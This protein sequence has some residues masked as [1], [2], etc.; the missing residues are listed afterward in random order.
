MVAKKRLYQKTMG[1]RISP[2]FNDVLEMNRL[3]N[4]QRHCANVPKKCLFG[5]YP[6]P[7]NCR[8]CICP[9]GLAGPTCGEPDNGTK[10]GGC[11]QNLNATKEVLPL[12]INLSGGSEKVPFT[13]YGVCH[14]T[15]EAPRN[16]HIRVKVDSM[17]ANCAHGC[18]SGGL[19]IR[20]AYAGTTG[21]RFCCK[22]QLT[23]EWLTLNT[24]TVVVS[25]HYQEKPQQFH[26]VYRIA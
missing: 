6:H 4:C 17:N 13:Q 7:K 26:L 14:W 10:P 23:D 8:Q 18:F 24:D 21:P 22:E 5:G 9:W 20:S 11:G 3:Y 19:E 2:T 25:V 1:S 15:I 12:A 16:S